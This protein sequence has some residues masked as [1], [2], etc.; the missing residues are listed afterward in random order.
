VLAV[1]ETHGWKV[2]RE[3]GGVKGRVR[4]ITKNGRTQ[5]AAIRT[6]QDGWIAFPRNGKDT[7]WVTLSDVDVVVASAI[8]PEQPNVAQ[9][10]V[11]DAKELR[12]RFDRAYTARRK[13]GH[14]I[15]IGR[16]IWV[17]LYHQESDDPVNRVGAGI[18]LLHKP[19]AT[20]AVDEDAASGGT[21]PPMVPT[22]AA[23][24]DDD[25]FEPLTIAEAKARLAR[26]LGVDPGSIKITVEA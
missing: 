20:V 1:L 12:E 14:R 16:G 10:H 9:V 21:Q 15:P 23:A 24:Y 25:S 5:L 6:S 19:I 3:K 7:R 11:F 2:S 18:G 8:N 4:Q 17:S 26:T 13:A 22:A